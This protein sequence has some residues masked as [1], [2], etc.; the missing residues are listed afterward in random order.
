MSIVD[1]TRTD[2]TS[3]R[4]MGEEGVGY[5][6]GR[7]ADMGDISNTTR[8]YYQGS[9]EPCRIE[10]LVPGAYLATTGLDETLL[11][12]PAGVRD[13]DG[14]KVNPAFGLTAQ[15]AI[16]RGLARVIA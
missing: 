6:F 7:D 9:T 16:T 8:G 12:C 10:I 4:Y 2:I 3:G 5:S 11:F 14:W 1:A 15:E 13:K